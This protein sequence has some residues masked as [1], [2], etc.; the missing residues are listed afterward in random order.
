MKNQEI[1]FNDSCQRYSIIIG[2]N[3]FGVL[4]KKIRLICP[5]T[6]QIAIIYDS[7]VPSKFRDALKSKLRNYKITFLKFNAN[8]K[9]KSFKS[10]E[11]YINK[12]LIISISTKNYQVDFGHLITCLF[13][14]Q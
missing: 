13:L 7:K 10:V 4:Q 6:K 11:F 12:L 5:N 9:T 8:E 3:L 2:N 14:S 1:K